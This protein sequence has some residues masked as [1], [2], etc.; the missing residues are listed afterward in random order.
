[1]KYEK[2]SYQKVFDCFKDNNCKL[3]ENEY[4][5]A[6]TKMKYLCSCGK[7]SQITYDSFRQGSRCCDCGILKGAEKRKLSYDAVKSIFVEAGCTLLE[8]E[9]HNNEQLLK[10]ICVCGNKANISLGNFKAGKRCPNC[11]STKLSGSNH[12]FW[13]KDRNEANLRKKTK[14][15]CYS[16][17]KRT[18]AAIGE[19]K[20]DSLLNHLGYSPFDLKQHL[21]SHPNWSNV[22]DKE[23][24]IDHLFPIK[25]FI[26]HGILDLKIIN[27]LSN[28]QPLSKFDNLSKGSNYD[29][30]EFLIYLNKNVV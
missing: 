2:L 7:I 19:V 28:L 27:A 10:Y 26:D 24:H 12:H 4:K 22:K 17:L 25:A 9:Y 16:L 21:E 18:L 5:N 30:T 13:I 15:K 14:Q 8:C 29:N 1:M 20:I 6:R 3:L 11:K 23:W